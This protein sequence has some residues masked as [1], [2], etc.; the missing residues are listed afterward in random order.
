[1]TLNAHGAVTHKRV[2]WDQGSVLK[3]LGLFPETMYC[4]ANSSE[5][6][7]PLLNGRIADSVRATAGEARVV[8]DVMTAPVGRMAAGLSSAQVRAGPCLGSGVWRSVAVAATVARRM[9]AQ[10]AHSHASH[11]TPPPYPNYASCLPQA[12]HDEFRSETISMASLRSVLPQSNEVSVPSPRKQRDAPVTSIVPQGSD[13]YARPISAAYRSSNIFSNDAAPETV[14]SSTRLHQQPGG[15]SSDIFSTEP[16][17]MRTGVAIDPRRGRSQIDLGGG[18]GATADMNTVHGRRDPNWSSTPEPEAE[19]VHH[20]GRRF[21]PG[22]GDSTFQFGDGSDG[23]QQPEQRGR[24]HLSSA[25]SS[26]DI[27]AAPE[28]HTAGLKR[29]DPNAR[30]EENIVRPSSR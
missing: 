8:A 6:R 25:S 11:P 2:Y 23:Q 14:R 24:K 17:P 22:V 27:F 30:C 20:S 16:M 13:A 26:S 9:S 1:M 28:P 10:S 15:K 7:L 29:R 5:V 3:Q 21:F 18:H 4:K 19:V 12:H